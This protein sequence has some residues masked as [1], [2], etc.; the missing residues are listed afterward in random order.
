MWL[1]LASTAAA[2]FAPQPAQPWD[3]HR[4]NPR[5]APGSPG[6]T[7]AARRISRP[8][9]LRPS[10]WFVRRCHCTTRLA[11]DALREIL[12]GRAD[13]HPLDPW[14][15]PAAILAAAARASSASSSTIAQTTTPSAS[16]ASS[17]SPN[18]GKQIRIDAGGGLVARPHPVAER[19]DD[20]IGRH[21]DVGRAAVDQ[22]QDRG[23]HAAHGADFPPVR[24]ARRRDRVEMAEQLVGPVDEVDVHSAPWLSSPVKSA[25][26]LIGRGLRHRRNIRTGRRGGTQDPQARIGTPNPPATTWAGMVR[27]QARHTDLSHGKRGTQPMGRCRSAAGS[28]IQGCH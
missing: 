26:E 6:S 22:P 25:S 10:S 1:N 14:A 3:S 19:L 4:R 27:F 5:R 8:P 18:C 2:D 7:R 17:S 12:V 28:S 16:S 21:P 23:D 9:L 13:Q 24:V 15:S 11:A 20:V